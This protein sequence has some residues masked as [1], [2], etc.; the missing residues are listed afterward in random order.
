M[1][2]EGFW[3]LLKNTYKEWSKD[4]ATRLAAALSFY[5]IFSLTPLVL[6]LTALLSSILDQESVQR[7]LILQLQDVFGREG[8]TFITSSLRA[9]KNTT[10]DIYITVVTFVSLLLASIGIF[11]HLKASFNTIWGVDKDPKT[12]ITVL[13]K[14]NFVSFGIVLLL[15]ALFFVSIVISTLISVIGTHFEELLPYPKIVLEVLNQLIAFGIITVLFGTFFKILPDVKLQW[16][17]VWEGA[18]FTSILFTLGKFLLSYYITYTAVASKYGAAGSLIIV[19]LWIYYSAQLLLFG[20]EFTKVYTYTYGSLAKP[21]EQVS[22]TAK[23]VGSFIEGF[24]KG[25]KK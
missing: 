4:K 5:A 6:I 8:A 19:L 2:K 3:H 24:L 22:K 25:I 13:V 20:A 10:H 16:S 21:T 14:R 17:D 7:V 1:K 12:D 23:M 18:L 9:Q 15:G 11:G